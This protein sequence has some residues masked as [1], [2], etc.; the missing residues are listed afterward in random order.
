MSS[1]VFSKIDNGT[2]QAL[3]RWGYKR[4]A[5]KGKRWIVKK[6]FTSFNGDNWRFHCVVKDKAG[7]KRPLYLKRASDTKIRRHVKIKSA[8]NPFDPEY[9][10]YFIEREAESKRRKIISNYSDTAGLRIIQS[11]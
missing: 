11:Y 6:Y 1:E 7:N 4:H 5:S 10:K 9:R 2:V 8:A 3:L